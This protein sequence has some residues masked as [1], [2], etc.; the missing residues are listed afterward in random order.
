MTM[1]A[2]MR[3]PEILVR[4]AWVPDKFGRMLKEC[5]PETELGKFIRECIKYLPRD[6]GITLIEK[7]TKSVVVQSALSLVHFRLDGRVEDVGVVS[8]KLVTTAG[9][10]FFVDAWQ[11]IVE[12]ENM[13]FHGIG[14]GVG[15]ESAADT[16]LGTEATTALAPDSTRA[17]GSLTEGASANIFRSVATVTVDAAVAMTEHGLLS[18]AATGGG[19]LWDRS[20]FAVQNLAIG[21]STQPTYDMTASSGG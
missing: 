18:Q 19:V 12:M 2:T 5:N 9:V 14:T 13:K 20:V 4:D 3:G 11:N 1:L 10:G 6:M 16:A 17:T 7:M 15:G 8:R 21:D